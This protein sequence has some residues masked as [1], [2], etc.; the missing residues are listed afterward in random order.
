[1]CRLLVGRDEPLAILLFQAL[2]LF[3]ELTDLVPGGRV[4]SIRTHL[5]VG[6]DPHASESIRIRSQAAVVR[7]GARAAAAG[8]QA[9]RL[10]VVRVP[11]LATRDQAL[12]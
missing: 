10:A 1:M 9:D 4:Q 5:G 2:R 12:Q 8:T 7:I 6:A 3:E 11:A